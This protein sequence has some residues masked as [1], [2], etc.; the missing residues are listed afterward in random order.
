MDYTGL[1][2]LLCFVLYGVF[3]YRRRDR[4]YRRMITDMGFG[5]VPV[6]KSEEPAP[7]RL[8]T[9]GSLGLLVILFEGYC[10]VSITKLHSPKY[11]ILLVLLGMFF[12]MILVFLV[13]MFIRDVRI[14]RNAA[15]DRKE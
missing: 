7:W 14:C 10:A 3:E 6:W 5:R 2:I 15:K 8:V 4:E 11:A 1:A 13:L 12:A 9:L